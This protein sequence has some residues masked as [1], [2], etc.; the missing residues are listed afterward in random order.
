MKLV[1]IESPFAG[2]TA[3]ERTDNM[4]YLHRCMRDSFDRGEAPFSSVMLYA[5]SHILDEDLREE[6]KLGIDAGFAWGAKADLVAVYTDRGTSPGVEL[7]IERAKRAGQPIEYRS[8]VPKADR[9]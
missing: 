7:G 8:L 4:I 5:M 3:Q 1:L 6:R 2:S 9:A